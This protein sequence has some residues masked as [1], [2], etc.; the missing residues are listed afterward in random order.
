M[1]NGVPVPEG[2]NGIT[3][4]IMIG[5]PEHGLAAEDWPLVRD[6]VDAA[7]KELDK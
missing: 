4:K 6:A 1:Y 7:L 5:M 3:R 2:T